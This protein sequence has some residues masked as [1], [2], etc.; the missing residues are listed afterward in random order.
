MLFG[1]GRKLFGLRLLSVFGLVE[2]SVSKLTVNNQANHLT[3]TFSH[4]TL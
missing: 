1:R 3:G 4:A 2:C